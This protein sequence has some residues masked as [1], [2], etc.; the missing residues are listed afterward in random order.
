[1]GLSREPA[2]RG[3]GAAGPLRVLAAACKGQVRAPRLASPSGVE[4]IATNPAVPIGRTAHLLKQENRWIR[5][6]RV[7]GRP[8]ALPII[9]SPSGH[10][11]EVPALQ[12]GAAARARGA[13]PRR[14]RGSRPRPVARP[15]PPERPRRCALLPL[16]LH[17]RAGSRL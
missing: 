15:P 8:D 12:R 16:S 4:A 13:V 3:V 10:R 7:G 9:R 14:G 1:M 17:R 11:N 2:A 5:A 6:L